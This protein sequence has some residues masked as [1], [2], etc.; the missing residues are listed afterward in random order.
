[1]SITEIPFQGSSMNPLFKNAS[2][3][4]VDLFEAPL[5]VD[6][7]QVVPGDIILYKESRGE[8]ICHR[9][10]SSSA[11]GLLLKGDFNTSM[12]FKKSIFVWG[13]V[14]GF[15]RDEEVYEVAKP[16]ALRWLLFAQRRQCESQ[17]Y[18]IKK[19]YR[20][21]ALFLLTLSKKVTTRKYSHRKL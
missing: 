5:A 2:H 8:W 21:L 19:F 16:I 18:F 14:R 10:L 1:M 7:R 6:S 12:E 13:V 3:V 15:I 17:T 4:L 20:T 11:E 9:C